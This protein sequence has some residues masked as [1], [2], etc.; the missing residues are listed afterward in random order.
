MKIQEIEG[1]KGI[2]RVLIFLSDKQ[3]VNPYMMD[4]WE[5]LYMRVIQSSLEK[6]RELGLVTVQ[7]EDS[8]YPPKRVYNLTKKGKKIAG[9]VRNLDKELED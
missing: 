9:I 4:R 2:L 5:G 8:G 6:L 7:L 3:N 1:Q